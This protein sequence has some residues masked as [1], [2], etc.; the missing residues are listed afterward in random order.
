[1]VVD[2]D[3]SHSAVMIKYIKNLNSKY[4]CYV[5]HTQCKY[6]LVLMH[7]VMLRLYWYVNVL[8]NLSTVD[9]KKSVVSYY[10]PDE[11]QKNDG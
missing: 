4:S 1:M 3:S 11:N 5:L 7:A 2:I 8:T 6:H 10:R 9:N